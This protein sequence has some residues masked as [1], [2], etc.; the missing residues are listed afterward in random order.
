MIRPTEFSARSNGGRQ[1]GRVGIARLAAEA[2]REQ[3]KRAVEYF[4]L[5]VRSLLNRVVSERVGFGWSIN[6]YRG[7]EFGCQ[8]CYARYTHEYMEL[9]PTEFE[10]KIYVKENA[11]RVLAGDLKPEK[12]R[13]EHI[14]IG[15]ATDPYQPAERMFGV[16]RQVLETLL[17]WSEEVP[18]GLV[19]FSLTTK[20][21]LVVRDAELLA[22][23]HARH[24]LHINFSVTTLKPRLARLLEP[25]APRP[26]L[27]LEAL[28]KLR[29]AGLVAGA[30]LSPVLPGITDKP[31]DLEAVV[32]AA[33]QAG[34]CYLAGQVVFLMP[35]AQQKFFPFLREKFPRLVQRYRKWYAGAGYAPAAYRAHIRDVLAGLRRRYHL[36]AQPPAPDLYTTGWLASSPQLALPI[37]AAPAEEKTPCREQACALA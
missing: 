36:A 5:P 27:R 4:R 28:R 20:S 31:E 2:P 33:A 29:E 21:D 17:A 15:T 23:L 24:P 12:L 1:A 30:F 19:S 3:Q 7:C 22:R 6:P 8:Y 37:G 16:T 32:A 13:G 9:G 26:D 18:R 11:A 34:A 10:R 14:A 25:R 35:S